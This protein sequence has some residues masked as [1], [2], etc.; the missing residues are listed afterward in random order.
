MLFYILTLLV[1]AI[2][3]LAKLWVRLHL[4]IGESIP[5]WDG[6][7][8]FTRYEN[9]GI[10]FSLLQG[11]G[12]L[13]VP[14]AIAVIAALIY[15]RRQGMLHSLLGQIGAALLAGGAAGN[16]LDRLLFSQVTDF[17]SFRSSSG[18][19]NLA[20][21]FIHAGLLLLIVHLFLPEKK[22]T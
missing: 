16:A 21:Y 5:I 13:F 4:E 14:V 12:R 7:L 17:I 10:A 22:R 11:Y 15:C 20:D 8:D 18:I 9:R 19:L 6:V 3:Q 1:I 2:D